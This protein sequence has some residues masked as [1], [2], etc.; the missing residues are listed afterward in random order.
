[1]II[2]KQQINI[3]FIIAEANGKLVLSV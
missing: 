1:M 2:Q 3:F